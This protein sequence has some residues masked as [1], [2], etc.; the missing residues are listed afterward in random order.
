MRA[1]L[2]AM[3]LEQLELVVLAVSI[4]AMALALAAVDWRLGL[5]AVG[6]LLFISV[7]D[8]DR[9]RRRT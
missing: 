3:K 5:F 2:K 8:L 6:L 7:F 1:R 9:L 4:G